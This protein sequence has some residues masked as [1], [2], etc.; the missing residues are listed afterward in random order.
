MLQLF[1]SSP[2]PT[3][4]SPALRE[5]LETLAGTHRTVDPLT[6]AHC[7]RTGTIAA[8]IA[9]TLGLGAARVEYVRLVGRIHDVGKH[10]LSREV[11]GKR[12]ALTADEYDLVESHCAFGHAA[13]KPLHPQ[14]ALAVLQHHERI[15]GSGYPGRLR[16]AAILP[17]ARIVA[18]ADVT[19]AMGSDRPYR[20][21]L[22]YEQVRDKLQREAG[23]TLDG[24]AVEACLDWLDRQPR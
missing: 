20:R 7:E 23:V 10:W 9:E 6:A 15:D 17:E 22:P 19:D 21:A 24:I 11:L 12:A 8:G 2:E 4:M 18:V 1:W 3:P 13:V 14:L 5:A 16:G